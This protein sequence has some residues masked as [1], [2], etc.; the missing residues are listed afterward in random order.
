M[1]MKALAGLIILKIIFVDIFTSLGDTLTDFLQ[2]W[3]LL[4]DWDSALGRYVANSCTFSWGLFVLVINWVPGL[5]AVVEI[6]TH[7]RGEFFGVSAKKTKID[8]KKLKKRRNIFVLLT[9]CC[10]FFYLIIVG[11]LENPFQQIA[12]FRSNPVYDRFGNEIFP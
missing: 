3:N 5:V 1:N 11:L 8:K 4:F 9:I 10:F 12:Q 7:Y 6:I 2:G